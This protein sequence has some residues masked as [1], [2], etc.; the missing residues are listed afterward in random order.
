MPRGGGTE[1]AMYTSAR[2]R[3]VAFG[4]ALHALLMYAMIDV[5]FA[6]PL[7][8]GMEPMSAD[9]APS[10]KRLVVIVADG[11]RADRLFELETEPGADAEV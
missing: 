2:F 7:V 8:H 11:L 3:L 5:N 10:A 9:F 1:G 4:V 6:T